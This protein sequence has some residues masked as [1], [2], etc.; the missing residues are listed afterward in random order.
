MEK[1]GWHGEPL[2]PCK[3]VDVVESCSLPPRS[4]LH[5]PTKRCKVED[6][7]L[8]LNHPLCPRAPSLTGRVLFSAPN[9]NEA[10]YRERCPGGGEDQEEGGD[11]QEGISAMGDIEIPLLDRGETEKDDQAVEASQEADRQEPC[12]PQEHPE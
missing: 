8:K 2:Q 5:F 10:I 9:A 1:P 3:V 12:R 4:P 6:R 7:Q 11:S